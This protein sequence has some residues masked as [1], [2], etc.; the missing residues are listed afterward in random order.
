V[1]FKVL[2]EAG[3]P[4]AG[5]GVENELAHPVRGDDPDQ[6]GLLGHLFDQGIFKSVEPARSLVGPREQ[7]ATFARALEHLP[8]VGGLIL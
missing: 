8:V 1:A 4:V 2:V 6:H 3:D 5:T 7:R